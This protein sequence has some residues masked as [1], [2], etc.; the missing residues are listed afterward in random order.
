MTINLTL[1]TDVTR[2]DGSH[3]LMLV[4]SQNTTRKRINL[5]L[6]L[7]PDQWDGQRVVNHPNEQVMNTELARIRYAAEEALLSLPVTEREQMGKVYPVVAQA[8]T[9]KQPGHKPRHLLVQHMRTFADG[10]P[11]KRTSMS[12]Y[13]TISRMEAYDPQVERLALDDVS[14]AW[15]MDFDMFMAKTAKSA[16]SRSIHLR[17]IRAAINDAINRE[18]TVNYPFR[19]FKIK[20][21]PT[22]HRAMTVEQLRKFIAADVLPHEQRYKDMFLL[23]FYLCG[24]APVDLFGITEQVGGRITTLR[25]KTSQPIDIRVEPEAME[26][27][28]R[29]KGKGKLLDIGWNNYDDFLKHMNRA[30]KSLGGLSYEYRKTK[31]GKMRVVAVRKVTWPGLS[32]YWA[33]HTW[34]SIANSIGI[35][36][37]VIG[38]AMGHAA[39]RV[40]DIYI[41]PDP[42]KVDEANRKVI[43]WVLFGRH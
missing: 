36:V 7:L 8:V 1:R 31:D 35:S 26:I 41:A 21:Q 38:Q 4:L 34:A 6:A 15:L 40:T 18:L 9:G 29:Y 23:M 32:A 39:R 25:S 20:S 16:N 3:P 37:D 10:H 22:P 43:D 19:R 11:N 24:L 5:G 14:V 33:R 28:E 30:L 13:H 12:Y 17:N 2:K 42:A 27:I